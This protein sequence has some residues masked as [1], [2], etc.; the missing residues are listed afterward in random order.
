MVKTRR[1]NGENGE[2][3]D[4]NYAMNDVGSVSDEKASNWTPRELRSS[5]YKVTR[6]IQRW[7]TK[8]NRR[9]RTI[10]MPRIVFPESDTEPEKYSRRSRQVRVFFADDNDSTN[11]S[12]KIRHSRGPRKNYMEDSEDKPIQENVRRSCR[13]RKLLHH[14]FNESWITNELKVKGYPDLYG[15]PGSSSSDESSSADE[16]RVGSKKLTAGHER[17]AP[18][19]TDE[20]TQLSRQRRTSARFNNKKA[21][22]ATETDSEDDNNQTVIEKKPAAENKKEE[23]IKTETEVAAKEHDKEETKEPVQAQDSE[24]NQAPTRGRR[25]PVRAKPKKDDS[26]QETE[27]SSSE[28]G[29]ELTLSRQPRRSKRTRKPKPAFVQIAQDETRSRAKTF[30]IRKKPYCLRERKPKILRRKT[31]RS[32]SPSSSTSSSTSSSDTEEDLNVSMKNKTKGRQKSKSMDDKK[33]DRA[34]RDIQPVEVDGSVRFTSVG[35]LEEHIKCLREMVLFPLMYPELFQKFKTRPAKGVLFHGPPGTGKTLLA[36]ALANECTLVGGRKVA[37]FMRKGADCLKKWVGESE[38]HLKLLFQQANKMKP[39]IIF[40]DE[41]DALAPVRSVRQEQVHTSV[42]GTLLAEMD[43][44]CDRGEVVIIGATNRLDAVDPALRRAGRFDRELHFPPPAADARRQIL[45]IYTRDW[46]PGPPAHTLDHLA[47][48]TAG[49]GGSDLKALCSEAVLKALRRVY[50]QVYES[51]HALVIDAKNVEVTRRDLECAMRSLVAAGGRAAPPAARR[52][53]A[54]ALPLL[55]AQLH[56][57]ADMLQQLFPLHQHHADDTQGT[58][59]TSLAQSVFLITGECAET[60]VAPALLAQLEH[61][62][63]KELSMATLH[64][65]HTFTQEQALIS[66]LSSIDVRSA[67]TTGAAGALHCEGAQHGHAAL[68]THLHAGTGAHIA[69]A[70]LAQLE[71]CTVKELSMATL[72]SAHTFTQEQALISTY[73]APA[74]LAQLEHCTVKELS[75][76]TLHSAHTFTQEQA[77]ISTYVAPALLAQLEHCTVKEL[78]MATLHSAHTFTQEQALISVFSEC[79]RADRGCVLFI[80]DI[81]LVWNNLSTL[82]RQLCRARAAGENTLLLATSD[83]SHDV[84]P[85]EI[86]EMFPVYKECVYRVREPSAAEVI[87]FLKPVLAEALL[88]PPPV[89]NN[90]PPPPLPLA[91]PPP[92]VRETAEEETR[93][94]RKE[95]YKLRELRIF[96]RDI[97]RKLASNRRFYKFTKPVDLE[98]VTD[99]LDIVKQPM[100]LETMMTKVDMHKYNCAKEFL[101]DID[102]ICANALEY[103]PDRTSSDKQIRHEAC[104]L[105]DHAHALIDVEM[106][107]DFELECQEIAKRRQEE[108]MADNDLPDFIYTASNLQHIDSLMSDKSRTPQNGDKSDAQSAKRKRRRMNAWSKGLV[109]KRPRTSRSFKD[110]SITITDEESKENKPITS[111]PLPNGEVST[112]SG[113]DDDAP[114]RR[115]QDDSVFNITAHAVVNNHVIESP[116]KSTE[117]SPTKTSPKKRNSGHDLTSSGDAEKVLINKTELDNVV[118]KNVKSLRN[119]GLEPLLNL[120]AQLTHAVR[121]YAAKHDRTKLPHELQAIVSRF[122][123]PIQNPGVLT[124]LSSTVSDWC[125]GIIKKYQ[126]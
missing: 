80:R 37:F 51:E 125:L 43:G 44:L 61:C 33:T 102:L 57:A 5:Q 108:G 24:S 58:S 54:H 124:T 9:V 70:L 93:R 65:A 106:D 50:P 89:E 19:N 62:T 105:R 87:N 116:A 77:L 109:V 47:E 34:L 97:C 85:P 69:P 29:S 95:D 113:S 3:D 41:I 66:V 115:P 68:R 32:Q 20:D 25:R 13:K 49:Y 53:P 22:D 27:S 42:V 16:T 45:D 119:I 39:S 98:E 52:L 4:G 21:N 12:V 18:T 82:L 101:D 122:V 14:N 31:I 107:S 88:E 23:E 15:F 81:V 6:K 90:E 28:S 91:P 110:T 78:S 56:A 71:H 104:S 11:R 114:L 7:P 64:S 48:L 96:L 120:H 73:V 1:S 17:T 63:V 10:K 46:Q 118:Y 100:D 84:L 126:V 123:T 92:P 36:R 76:A 72:H 59:E 60:Y 8:Y 67:R 55:G 38:R 2:V 75:M 111:T 86:Q 26:Q 79:R 117:K 40:F 35:G 30:T 103:N 74:L 112:S 83:V 121:A 94:K 99:Y